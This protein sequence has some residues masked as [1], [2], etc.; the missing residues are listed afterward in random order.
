VLCVAAAVVVAALRP[1]YT[2]LWIALLGIGMV[3]LPMC[4]VLEA[5]D[6]HPRRRRQRRHW[7]HVH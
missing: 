2:P 5:N 4:A 6:H 3:F 1:P 7:L